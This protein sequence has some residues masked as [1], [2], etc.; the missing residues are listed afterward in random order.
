MKEL[1]SEF[2]EGVLKFV[3]PAMADNGVLY[4][5][6]TPEFAKTMGTLC[7]V[8]NVIVPNMTEASFMLGLEYKE[9]YDEAYVKDVLKRLC[10]LGA[11]KAI[12]TGVAHKK[13]KLGTMGYDPEKNEYFEHYNDALPVKYHGTGDVYSSVCLGGLV[14]GMSLLDAA[15]LA[16]DFTVLSMEKTLADKGSAWYGVN[17]EEAIPFLIKK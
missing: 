17:F 14:N 15:S 6:F 4:A 10:D 16:A 13:G 7:A 2:G 5:G 11:K 8:A 3:D 12:I 1:F 9:E